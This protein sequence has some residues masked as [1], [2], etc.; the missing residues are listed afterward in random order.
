MEKDQ[1]PNLSRLWFKSVGQS[2]RGARMRNV[3]WK[4]KIENETQD[5]SEGIETPLVFPKSLTLLPTYWC[6]GAAP[7]EEEQLGDLWNWNWWWECISWNARKNLNWTKRSSC[8]GSVH[9][10]GSTLFTLCRK[11]SLGASCSSVSPLFPLG[12]ENSEICGRGPN[13]VQKL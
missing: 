12:M 3:C 13:Y 4:V 8:H 11:P 5:A 2:P 1:W 6:D 9:V 7:P 10:V